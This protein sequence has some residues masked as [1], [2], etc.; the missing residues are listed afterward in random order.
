M[1]LY[2][3]GEECCAMKGGGESEV[4]KEE[5]KRKNEVEISGKVERSGGATP[6]LQPRFSRP[7]ELYPGQSEDSTCKHNTGTTTARGYP[8][9]AWR[10]LGVRFFPRIFFGAE[11]KEK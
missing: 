10:R 5:K 1:M 9:S 2:E 8:R 4:E 6:K 7:N 3:E 11:K